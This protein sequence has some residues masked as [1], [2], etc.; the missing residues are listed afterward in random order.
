MAIYK[1]NA[2]ILRSQRRVFSKTPAKNTTDKPKVTDERAADVKRTYSI[3]Y[4]HLLDPYKK[5]EF[6][7]MSE[8]DAKALAQFAG[9]EA[10]AAKFE[11]ALPN[12]TPCSLVLTPYSELLSPYS[13][14]TTPYCFT[15]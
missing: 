8:E 7:D 4:H 2:P 3:A 1:R 13:L 15:P 5:N 12:I 9:K 6:K 10:V 14:L 11:R